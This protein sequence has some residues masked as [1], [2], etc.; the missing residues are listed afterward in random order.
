MNGA[1]VIATNTATS[2]RSVQFS[3]EKR[4]Y[5]VLG[6]QPGTCSLHVEAPGF[7]GYDQTGIQLELNQHATQMS[8]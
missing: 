7:R 5:T 2:E 4:E 3:N 6:L 8:C 1:N